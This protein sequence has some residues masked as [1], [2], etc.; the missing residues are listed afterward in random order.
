MRNWNVWE[1]E[2]KEKK[3][4]KEEQLIQ[5]SLLKVRE[6]ESK[7]WGGEEIGRR[8]FLPRERG[9]G[10][11]VIPPSLDRGLTVKKRGGVIVQLFYER[12]GD[13]P[14]AALNLPGSGVRQ[15]VVILSTL[16][17]KEGRGGGKSGQYLV[18][19]PEEKEGGDC[20]AH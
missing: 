13:D 20:T 7:R 5:G 1:R 4:R 6:F 8:E 14:P 16:V 18:V 19:L 9:N 11:S 3:R 12:R 2:E 17:F 15:R 10:R